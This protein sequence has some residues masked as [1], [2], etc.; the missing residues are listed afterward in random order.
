MKNLIYVDAHIFSWFQYKISY[1]WNEKN[2]KFLSLTLARPISEFWIHSWNLMCYHK[3]TLGGYFGH[4]RFSRL[5]QNCLWDNIVLRKINPNI[6]SCFFFFYLN[7]CLTCFPIYYC[8][9]SCMNDIIIT[10][11]LQTILVPFQIPQ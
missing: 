1:C 2:T 11:F 6:R 10:F 7:F 9:P 3:A 4:H 8:P 5:Y